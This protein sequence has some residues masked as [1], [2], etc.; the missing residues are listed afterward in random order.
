V[1]QSPETYNAQYTIIVSGKNTQFV[2]E[3]MDNILELLQSHD[4]EK[5]KDEISKL[6]NVNIV[7]KYGMSYRS[8]YDFVGSY[9]LW[10]CQIG[11]N[12]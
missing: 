7:D 4:W 3:L 11:T 6:D 10:L 2:A 8:L 1:E 9:I 12:Q 5:A